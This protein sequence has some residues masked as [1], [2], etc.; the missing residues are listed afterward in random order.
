MNGRVSLLGADWLERLC[1]AFKC[2]VQFYLFLLAFHTFNL[3]WLKFWTLAQQRQQFD[4]FTSDFW[5]VFLLKDPI[6]AKP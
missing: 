2:E 5:V 6:L 1:L 4:F 3:G